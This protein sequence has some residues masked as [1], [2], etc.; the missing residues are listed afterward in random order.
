MQGFHGFTTNS[1]LCPKRVKTQKNEL[2]QSDFIQIKYQLQAL[3]SYT[4]RYH[5]IHISKK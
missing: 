5:K 4:V 2:Q 3:P 1:A